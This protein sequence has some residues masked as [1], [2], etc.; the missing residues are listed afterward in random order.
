MV[1]LYGIDSYSVSACS[2]HDG[3]PVGAC[4]CVPCI[5]NKVW[6]ERFSVVACVFWMV[7]LCYVCASVFVLLREMSIG[8]YTQEGA[9]DLML[10]RLLMLFYMYLLPMPCCIQCS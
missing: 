2:L 6:S 7:A 1:I 9:A 10:Q 5:Y 4:S 3:I 8:I